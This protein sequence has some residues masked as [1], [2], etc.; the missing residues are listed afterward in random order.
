MRTVFADTGYW[1][2]LLNPRDEL[3]GVALEIS[4]DL[5]EVRILTTEMVL[6]ELLSGLAKPPTRSSVIRGVKS[7]LTNPN[8]E[9]VPQ[10]AIQFREAFSLYTSRADKDW[11]LTDCASFNLMHERGITESLA[12]DD[13]F[14]QAGFSALLRRH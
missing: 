5:R 9:V 13:D 1:K 10:T 3:H 12:Y 7:I 11:S 14:E 8:V 2:A 4:S 6:D